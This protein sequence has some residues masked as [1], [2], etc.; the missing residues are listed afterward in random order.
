MNLL[1]ENI[2]LIA[3]EAVER[4]NFFLIDIIIRGKSGSRIIE[5]YVDGEKDVSADDCALISREIEQHLE[6][7][8]D[9]GSSYRLDVSSPGVDR[10]L[11]FLRQFPKHINRKF[12]LTY[13]QDEENKKITAKLVNI[14][15]DNLI[16]LS[17]KNELTINYNNLTKAK[18]LV[19]F[20]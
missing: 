7:I 8:P 14:E 3:A 1:D 10:P 17:G 16:F 12:E 20:S 18:V 13:L 9:I 11:K 6:N 2:K 4:N 15:G 19:S 5:I